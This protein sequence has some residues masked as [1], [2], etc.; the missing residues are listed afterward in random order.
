MNNTLLISF[1]P[2]VEWIIILLF[3][4]P[5]LFLPLYALIDILRSDFRGSN[6]KILWFLVVFF[7][8]MLGSILYFLIGRKQKK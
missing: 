6:D 4:T 8:P 7:I 3:L 2:G 5:I 1:P